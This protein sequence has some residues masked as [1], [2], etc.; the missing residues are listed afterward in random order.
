MWVVICNDCVI[1]S[2]VMMAAFFSLMDMLVVRM[3]MMMISHSLNCILKRPGVTSEDRLRLRLQILMMMMMISVT[4]KDR[5]ISVA[6]SLNPNVTSPV[7]RLFGILNVMM[8]YIKLMTDSLN[9][10]GNNFCQKKSSV[11]KKVPKKKVP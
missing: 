7:K 8:K 9:M 3:M 11:K 5:L 1:L 6:L 2:D 10:I 4:W